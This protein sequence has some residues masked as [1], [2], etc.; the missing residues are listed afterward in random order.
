[1]EN[2]ICRTRIVSGENALDIL[3]T[4]G[5]KTLLLV[6]DPYFME[7]GTAEKL[8]QMTGAHKKE[9]FHKVTPDPSVDLVAAG[10]AQ[11]RELSPDTV[12]ALGGGSTLDCAKAMVHFSGLSPRLI[13]IP[14]T[15]GS[16]SEV[17]N[18][19]VLTHGKVKHPIV[20]DSLQPEMA[21]LD[22]SLLTQLPKSLIADT[23]FDVLCHALESYVATG[24]GAF[25]AALAREAFCVAYAN[26][27]ASYGGNRN[28][29]GRV[30]QAATMAGLAFTHSGLGLC[31]ALSHALGGICHLPH[32]RLNAILLP[33]VIRCNSLV[34]AGQYAA[35]ARA[36]GIAG[37]AESVAVRNLQNAL[38]RLRKELH[39]PGTLREAGVDTRLIRGNTEL[40]K[41]VLEDPCCKTNPLPVE[42]YT[43]RRILEE[44]AGGV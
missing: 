14:T 16:G 4:L 11:L 2:F 1:M 26:L 12:I 32:G 5:C 27:P 35:I 22:D 41:A 25:S 39:M 29:R 18:F 20:E 28:V 42:D 30:H 34:C 38:I 7:N 33:S 17:T 3:K 19:A 24:T 6:C 13:A 36:A 8:A 10:T 44:V 15:S 43:V 21:I 23:G 40:V 9:I 37:A 31:H